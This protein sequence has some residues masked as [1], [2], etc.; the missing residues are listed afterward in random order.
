MWPNNTGVLLLAYGAPEG[1]EDIRDFLKSILG[2]D[3][4]PEH[5]LN[6]VRE[7]YIAIGG[8]SPFIENT[9]KQAEELQKLLAQEDPVLKVYAG[10]LHSK[11]RIEEAILKATGE[12]IK[13]FLC[14]PLT[15]N[16]NYFT[17][18]AYIKKI[19]EVSSKMGISTFFVTSWHTEP[20]YIQLLSRRIKEWLGKL[21]PYEMEESAV[22]F[23][24]H[25][26]PEDKIPEGD[27]YVKSIRETI[28]EIINL[29]GIFPYTL[30]FQSR[31]PGKDR[32]LSPD[33]EDTVRELGELGTKRAFVVPLS[34]VC[35][36]L[37]TLYDIDIKLNSVSRDAGIKLERMR[38]F[39]AEPEFI[40]VLKHIVMRNIWRLKK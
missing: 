36:H 1:V 39:N 21:T 9:M 12:G 31:R 18:G 29:V 37:E 16:Y 19:D 14:L 2:T 20:L 15:P 4:I 33:V 26:L 5:Y 11:P 22:I 3:R 32:W 24:A 13:N 17:T 8:R 28:Q 27:P 23:T 25:S 35:D 6:S 40:N 38:A 30:A 7:K 10:M 34:F